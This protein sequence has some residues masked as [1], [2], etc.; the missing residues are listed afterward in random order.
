LV[1]QMSKAMGFSDFV[2]SSELIDEIM[3]HMSGQNKPAELR[4]V[5][6]SGRNGGWMCH[7]SIMVGVAELVK[8]ELVKAE[9]EAT[10][11][12]DCARVVEVRAAMARVV[13][14]QRVAAATQRIAEA[15]RVAA[16]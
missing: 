5:C 15:R 13:E 2:P 6:V 14:A 9:I 12:V 4:T 8:A 10:R 11:V 16:L 1:D 7:G 3:R